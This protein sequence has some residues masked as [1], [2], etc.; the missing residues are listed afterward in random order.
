MPSAKLLGTMLLTLKGTPYLYQGDEL[1]MTNYP[2]RSIEEY[3]DIEAKN[4]WQHDVLSGQESSEHYLN[5]LL[6]VSRDHARTPMQWDASPNAGFTSRDAKPWLAVNPNYTTVNAA[7]ALADPSSVY[8]YSQGLVALRK[9]SL[10]F[11][12]GDYEDLAPDHS[13]LFLYRRALGEERFLVALN[14]SR[15]PLLV[16]WPK[17]FSQASLVLSNMS[18][19]GGEAELAP[20]ESR[21][22]RG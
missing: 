8:H 9:S 19:A 20:W 10:A 15:E 6:R 7:A 1:G 11:V 14:F 16:R 17:A 2:F 22:L 5:N 21:I 13:N 4:A 12:Y 3:N 18:D